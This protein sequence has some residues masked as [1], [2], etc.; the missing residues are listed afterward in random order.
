MWRLA[1]RVRSSLRGCQ[2][3]LSRKLNS[4][5]RLKRVAYR[6]AIQLRRRICRDETKAS[7]SHLKGGRDKESAK[8]NP[9]RRH[10]GRG[11]AYRP[12]FAAA[13][14][15][16]NGMNY[17][18]SEKEYKN[19][20]KNKHKQKTPLFQP[21]IRCFHFNVIALPRI[22]SKYPTSVRCQVRSFTR[23][24]LSVA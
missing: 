24:H 6:L 18:Q 7:C 9:Y 1:K 23:M 2:P 4:F 5:P 11:A 14:C 16:G 20:N 19:K 21:Q 3:A 15:N 13:R 8:K 12:I 10:S 22:M 17:L